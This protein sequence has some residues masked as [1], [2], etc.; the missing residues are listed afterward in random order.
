MKVAVASAAEDERA[1]SLMNN[2]VNNKRK[3][4]LIENISRL[5]MVKVLEKSLKNKLGYNTT[6]Q[7]VVISQSR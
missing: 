3:A 5:M 4:L 1:F 6:H 2:I 7:T